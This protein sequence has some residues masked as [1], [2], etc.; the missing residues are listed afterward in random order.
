MS[1]FYDRVILKRVGHDVA[2]HHII[3]K[4]RAGNPN[5]I[6]PIVIHIDEHGAFIS[7]RNSELNNTD[8]KRYFLG[9]LKLLGSAATSS[10]GTLSNLHAAG[11][12]FLVSITTGTSHSAANINEVS[13]YGIQPIK[14]PVLTSEQSRELANH[15]FRVRGDV[16]TQLIDKT[17]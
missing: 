15:C 17:L 4:I 14:L 1:A 6:V 16:T 7:D 10:E 13:G 2:L 3:S 9:M 5:W 12:Y 8:G 11:H